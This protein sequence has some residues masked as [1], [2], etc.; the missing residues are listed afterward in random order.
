MRGTL[1][2]F[3]GAMAIL[4]I[5]AGSSACRSSRDY[6]ADAD[7]LFKSNRYADAAL[8]YRKA[9]Q[10][11]PKSADAYYKL[12]LALR[13][14]NHHAE[15]YDSFLR[16]VSLNPEHELAQIELG[17]LY[18]G[19][20]LTEPVKSVAVYQK[21]AAVADRLL[22]K[23]SKSYAGLRLR[24]YLA[25]SDQKPEEAISFFQR[26][27]E[28]NPM[29]PD[30]VLGLTQGLLMAGH[31]AEARKTGLELIEKN[32]TFG[33]I[34][35]V[36]YAYESSTGHAGD[37]GSLLKLKVANNPQNS[38]FILQLAQHYLR[39]GNR[40]QAS[41]LLD[42]MLHNSQTAW[43]SY[44]AV[45]EFYRQNRDWDRAIQALDLGLKTH[46]E[47][48]LAFEKAKAELLASEGKPKEAVSILNQL[49]QENPTA[50]DARK[51]RAAL[52]M[53]SGEKS[54]KEF[55]LRELQSLAKTSG[56]DAGVVFQ[57][58]RAYAM[59]G[60][61]DQARQQFELIIKRDPNHIPG[62]LALAE[63]S[64][65]EKQFRQALQYSDRIMVLNPGLR[66]ARLLH[67]TALVGLGQ[68]DQARSEYG[69]LSRD[70]PGYTEARLQ[71]AMLDVLQKRFVESEK[72][73][74]EAYRPK[75]GDFR[76]LKGLV[77][78]D[79]AQGHWE[80]AL[81]LLTT[82]LSRFPDST[83]VR[84]LLASTA[85]RAGKLD[86]AVQHYE[87]LL[88]AQ[89][90][91]AEVYTQLGQIYRRRHDLANSIVMFQ[92]ARELAP[93]DWRTT[94]RLATVQQEAG[95][96][97]EAKGNYAE[98]MRLGGDEPGLLN[99]LA[100]VEAQM[101]SNLDDA[102]ALAQ[103]ALSRS[104]SDPQ[105]ADTVGFIYLKKKETASAMRVFHAL[106]TRYPNQALF[107]YHL[108]LALIQDGNQEQARRECRLAVAADPA[109]AKDAAVRRLLGA[110]VE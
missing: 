14:S 65:T 100:Y 56:N 68:L 85:V 91:T 90:E 74:R 76:A 78:V 25:M 7:R 47:Q 81:N 107:R 102:L 43:H 40:E 8:I 82:E 50:T 70:E 20:Y 48:K 34:Y 37:A 73:F 53:E 93:A 41:R 92:K 83:A 30:V 71:L 46:P 54:D 110:K 26:A 52:L 11:D 39:S 58:G 38:A 77:E 32:K 29:Q 12:G 33:P 23:D 51:T 80:K 28:V 75:D 27:N 4:A 9:I 3:R 19:D 95:L 57:L 99:N 62:L 69:K 61:E 24:G 18:L 108:A 60:I 109:L 13:A 103:K 72:L 66:N 36:L 55:A 21:V 42:E 106:S 15:A 2:K 10:K 94:A 86:L 87:Q 49:L 17:D 89:G 1:N 104:P 67:A 45:G 44:A 63:I 84:N 31:Y 97:A 6:T 5:L 88:H 98:A 22:A 59:N 64:S 105:C 101:G 79:A 16:A 35:D 96:L